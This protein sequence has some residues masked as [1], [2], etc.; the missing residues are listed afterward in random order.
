MS[1][2]TSD[3]T[4]TTFG[5]YGRGPTTHRS[6]LSSL[7]ASSAIYVAVIALIVAL[8]ATKTIIEK[9]KPVELKFVEKVV[10]EPPPPP[11]PVEVKPEIKPQPPAAAAPVVRPDQKIR[12]LDKPPPPK[13]MVAPT[14]MPQ[15]APKEAD[16]S[17][18]KGIAVYGEGGK[19]DPAGL[20]GGVSKGG[21]AGGEVGGAV[22]LP[23]DAVPP[24]PSESNDKP[25]Y[26]QEARA[27]GQQGTVVLKV[28]ILADGTVAKVE[29]LRGEEPFK[30]AAVAAVKK[31]KYSPAMHKG[32][33]I[34]VYRIIQ[35][36]FK[37]TA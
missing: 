29:V 3:T 31:W 15:A 25:T 16:P 18:D 1:E 5:S 12:R 28:T 20:E 30:S 26:P 36:P 23:E 19:G 11:P 27:T 33:P 24:M 14:E 6:W 34:T 4:F 10:K 2:T 9:T 8:S 21:V 37:L 17:E 13:K 32:Q 22:A 7:M 35:I